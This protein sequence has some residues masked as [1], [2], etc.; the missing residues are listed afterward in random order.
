MGG[1]DDEPIGLLSLLQLVDVDVPMI[2]AG[3][4]ATPQ[5]VQAVIALGAAAAQVG[6]AF[7]RAPEAGTTPAHTDRLATNGPTGLTR[8]FSGRRARGIVNRF[9]DEHPDAPNAYPEI[10]YA[11]SQLRA[12]AR[13]QGDSD[14]FNLWAGQ[15]YALTQARPAAE[16]TRY[17]AGR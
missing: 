16:I 12:E 10:H 5:A 4:I 11:T 6:T 9:M 8:A 7:L 13:K 1:H 14:G 15:A 2:A 17:L 3:G